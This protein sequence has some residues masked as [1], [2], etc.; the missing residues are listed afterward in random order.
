MK[1]KSPKSGY[2]I[3]VGGKTYKN[4][5]NE[6]YFGN[7]KVQSPKTGRYI[8]HLEKLMIIYIKKVILKVLQVL[9]SLTS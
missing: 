3:T 2:L 1:V 8:K 7:K 9:M 6:G 5:E 4:L